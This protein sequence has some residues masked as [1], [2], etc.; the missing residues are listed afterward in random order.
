ML[1][2]FALG[3]V[4]AFAGAQEHGAPQH[5]I[6]QIHHQQ[7]QDRQKLKVA[8][9]K[10]KNDLTTDVK[11]AALTFSKFI[12]TFTKEI[13]ESSCVR[14]RLKNVALIQ[15]GSVARD[16]ASPYTDLECLFLIKKESVDIRRKCHLVMQLMADRL[17]L[18]GEGPGVDYDGFFC[19]KGGFTPP[20][21]PWFYRCSNPG[22]LIAQ[23]Q[24]LG[25]REMIVT[26]DTLKT[27]FANQVL[28]SYL[29]TSH[30]V[31][32]VSNLLPHLVNLGESFDHQ[33][34]AMFYAGQFL[35][36]FNG[37]E[38]SF[39]QS[40]AANWPSHVF[41]AGNQKLYES[42]SLPPILRNIIR[43]HPD[44]PR[45]GQRRITEVLRRY[46]RTN[47]FDLESG[48]NAPLDFKYHLYRPI[49]QFLTGLAEVHELSEKN[50][51]DILTSLKSKELLSQ[52]LIDSMFLVL[53]Y[54][55]KV[56]FKTQLTAKSHTTSVNFPDVFKNCLEY[57][58]LAQNLCVLS[59]QSAGLTN[60]WDIRKHDS[61]VNELQQ[62]SLKVF[63]TIQSKMPPG[64]LTLDL[65][66]FYG[67]VRP[68]F[69]FVFNEMQLMVENW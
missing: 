56:G 22:G 16:E 5:P 9:A 34:Q 26:V 20:Y 29:D 53:T 60:V 24:W 66:Y 23:D 33:A 57:F 59:Q 58:Q 44:F 52:E 41:V 14:A 36:P 63:N 47:M 7:I 31:V 13:F 27:Y 64:F 46:K 39:Q 21:N 40:I 43:D 54:A 48:L 1:K 67:C 28:C 19:D 4:C 61:R 6:E 65:L 30:A 38:L 10:F 2:Y 49:E 11:Q 35:R 12:R 18:A 42:L 3:L 15:L 50:C 62:Q 17:Y 37:S 55:L 32:P 8:R 51:F 25:R 45:I 69:L 68:T